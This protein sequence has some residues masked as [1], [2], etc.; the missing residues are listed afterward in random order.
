MRSAEVHR[1]GQFAGLG[2]DRRL[3]VVVDLGQNGRSGVLVQTPGDLLT[4]A[5]LV[6]EVAAHLCVG[7]DRVQRVEVVRVQQVQPHTLAVDGM[8]RPGQA[9]R[10]IVRVGLMRHP[11]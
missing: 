4:R 3:Q 9:H 8:E 1:A 5:R 6:E 7:L 10:S 11:A 2:A